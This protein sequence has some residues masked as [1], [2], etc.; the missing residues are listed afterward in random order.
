MCRI[1]QL[2]SQWGVYVGPAMPVTF[3][4]VDAAI[5]T[6]R[7]AENLMD[8]VHASACHAAGLCR[9]HGPRSRT[10]SRAGIELRIEVRSRSFT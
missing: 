4:R 3:G 6:A 8:R 9:Q 7:D 10:S 1:V 5:T 2:D